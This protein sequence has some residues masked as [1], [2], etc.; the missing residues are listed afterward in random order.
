MFLKINERNTHIQSLLMSKDILDSEYPGWSW[1]H[2]NRDAL[3][4]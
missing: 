4:F 1:I 2:S 3:S